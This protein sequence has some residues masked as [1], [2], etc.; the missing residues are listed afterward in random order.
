MLATHLVVLALAA[1][2]VRLG[3]WQLD[4]LE[5]RRDSNAVASA[6]L[7]MPPMEVQ[8]LLAGD[9]S[10]EELRYRRVTAT[11]VLDPTEE[12]L[13]RSQVYR[14]SAGF[15]VITPMRLEGGE[16]ILVNRGWVPQGFDQVPVEQAPPPG[17]LVTVEGWIATTQTRPPLGR[18]D[19]EGRLVVMNRVDL[20]RIETQLPYPIT[21]V[22]MVELGERAQPPIPVEAPDF[23]DEG[24][25][26]A[27]A[28]QWFAFAVI[29]VVGYY[30]L[31][32]RR[33]SH[34]S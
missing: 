8:S 10:P 33:F 5:E 3:I 14:G 27:Y 20:D 16:A 6:R 26:L 1:L 19:P 31:L 7:E 11:G 28:I 4:R 13:I 9:Q 29:G 2:F 34:L 18:E 15:H 21:P 17:G 22:Y 25:H 32:R 24:P 23:T 30:F 12:V